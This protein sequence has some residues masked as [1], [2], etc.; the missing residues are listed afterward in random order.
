MI[1]VILILENYSVG[2]AQNSQTNFSCLGRTT[3]YYADVDKGCQVYH[4]CDGLGR[5]FSYTCPN[6]TLFQQR[7][8]I[9]DHWYM[10]N[11]SR[12]TEDYS[13][14]LLIGQRN[15]KFLEDSE[16][17]HILRTPRPDLLVA[18]SNR[19]EYNIVYRTGEQNLSPRDFV[20]VESEDESVTDQPTYFPPSSWSTQI[21]KQTSTPEPFTNDLNENTNL[22]NAQRRTNSQARGKAINFSSNK[23]RNNLLG[24]NKSNFKA[25]TPVYP[26]TIED[27]TQSPNNI[28]LFPPVQLANKKIDTLPENELS[29]ELLPPA[30]D[31]DL[32]S[33]QD[34]SAST[35]KVNFPSNYKATTPQYPS[36]DEL[37]KALREKLEG[38]NDNE[39]SQFKV[40]FKSNFK[41]TTPVYP[42]LVDPTSVDPDQLGILPPQGNVVNFHSNF[43]ATTPQYPT[44][45]DNTSPQPDE[46]GLL[47][48]REVE[49]LS[50]QDNKDPSIRVNF[51][52]NF[53]ATTPNYPSFVDQ[54][55]V[56]PAD[57]GLLPP[58]GD[59]D[60][61]DQVIINFQSNFK[62]TTPQ[63]PNYVDPTSPDPND[64]GLLPPNNKDKNNE[65]VKVN[66]NIHVNFESNFKATTP[67][68]PS[69]VDPTSPNPNDIGL[70][71][72]KEASRVAFKSKFRATTPNYPTSVETTS[73]NPYDVGLVPPLDTI[74]NFHSDYKATTPNYPTFVESTSPD[75]QQAGLLAPQPENLL[76]LINPI[77]NQ[78]PKDSE[79]SNNWSVPSKFYQPPS[80]DSDSNVDEEE[81][82]EIP[83]IKLLNFMKSFNNAQW[84]ELRQAFRI[85][86]YDFPLDDATRPSYDSV[87]NSFEPVSVKK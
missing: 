71:P 28:G 7:M 27:T 1:N 60:N 21:I 24:N 72:P 12:A 44:S 40:N 31:P 38:S 75:P 63:Y 68:Y 69:Y 30:I 77:K 53:K 46:A 87:V 65:N 52:S 26:Q 57:A 2:P 56:N 49:Q 19:T 11:C 34:N 73:A 25:T 59:E 54:T 48:P 9:C 36:E 45:V 50:S 61:T 47:P 84:Q 23:N 81:L 86:E 76:G 64:A 15:R 42:N 16:T 5:Q 6:A 66:E 35:I 13:A 80:I 74:V 79:F 43:K 20:G 78:R 37:T 51:E 14:N 10:V 55:S 32:F 4:M 22:S 70:L 39:Q 41:A 29:L 18:P 33:R 17:L 85:P 62:A 8:L 82:Q 67:Q 83:G 58:N 3:G